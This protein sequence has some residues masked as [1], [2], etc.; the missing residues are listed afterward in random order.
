MRAIVLE[1][2]GGPEVLRIVERER[3]TPSAGEVLIQIRAFGLNRSELFTRQGHSPNVKLP[4]VLGIECV[5]TVVEAPGGELEPGQK[6]AVAMGGMGRAFDGSYAEFTCVPARLAITL[7]TEL[8]WDILGAIP[9]MFQTAW[10]CLHRGLE[11]SA[12]QT[13]LIR[14]GTTSIGMT[15]ARLAKQL[16]MTVLATTRKKG[17]LS[18][19]RANGVD[20]AI[21]DTGEIAALV[22]QHVPTGVDRALEL[23]GATTLR[24]TLRCAAPGGVVCMTGMVG[25]KWSFTDFSPMDVIP[26]TVKLTTYSGGADDVAATPL[27]QFVDDVAA[28]RMQVNIDRV[29]AFD[30]IVGAHRYMEDNRATGKLVVVV[31]VG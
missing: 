12:G 16:G 13:L 26:H 14:G 5:G 24:D 18:V 25:G 7:D 30:D 9:E 20:R 19:L 6:V 23:V 11:A 17:R 4:R 1:R 3:P 27:Q 10:G 22:R 2:P 21:V 29:F 28:D 15:V 8:P 31:D